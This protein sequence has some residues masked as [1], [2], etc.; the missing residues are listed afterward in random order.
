MKDP[1]EENYLDLINSNLQELE[2]KIIAPFNVPEKSP[3]FIVGP[4][5]SGSTLLM[6]LMLKRYRLAYPNNFIA[7]FWK[8]PLLGLHLY[9]SIV[10]EQEKKD[11][12]L[13]SDL[14]YTRGIDGPHEFGYFWRQWFPLESYEKTGSEFHAAKHKKLQKELAA[15]EN[16]A[17][18][19]LIFKNLIVNSFYINELYTLFPNALFLYIKRNP[20][21]VVFSTHTSRIKLFGNENSWFGL[22]P[23]EFQ[24][25]KDYPLWE[26][27]A[28]Q[29]YY[30]Q[31]NIEDQLINIPAASWLSVQYEDLVHDCNSV[32]EQIEVKL[33][34][35]NSLPEIISDQEIHLNAA[36][37]EI[38]PGLRRIIETSLNKFFNRDQG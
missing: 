2:E 4:Q 17:G 14:G 9:R 6:Q 33:K 29:V 36:K 26:Q 22:K 19:G 1:V 38:D 15:W 16:N 18:C 12:D 11:I 13:N 7:R 35:L 21:D 24:K 5:R 10:S 30:T 32:F 20:L 37:K 23:V 8:A 25:L 34:A 3:V 27:I 28:G 31:K